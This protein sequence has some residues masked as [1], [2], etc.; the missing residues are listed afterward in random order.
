MRNTSLI[1]RLLWLFAIIIGVTLLDQA[2]KQWIVGWL[3]PGSVESRFELLG[4]FVAFEYLE[5]RGAAFGVF[6]QGTTVL[7]IL[8]VI[9]IA[10]G[11]FAMVRFASDQFWLAVSIALLLGGAAGNAIDRFSR[12]YVIDFIAI[13]RFWKFNLADSAVTIGAILTFVLLWRAESA[14]AGNNPIQEPN[15]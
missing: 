10:V 3:G 14:D 4:S 9:I 8:S 5:N 2:T 15:P 6:Q 11:F 1:Q 13:G 12:G 7:A